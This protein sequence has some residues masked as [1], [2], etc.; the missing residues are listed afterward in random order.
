MVCVLG[1]KF[2]QL[3][4]HRQCFKRISFVLPCH[5]LSDWEP[6]QVFNTFIPVQHNLCILQNAALIRFT[7]SNTGVIGK[8]NKNFSQQMF[9]TNPGPM[10]YGEICYYYQHD[11][12]FPCTSRVVHRFLCIPLSCTVQLLWLALI[13]EK[14]VAVLWPWGKWIVSWPNNCKQQNFIL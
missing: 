3:C 9:T 10:S 5:R 8:M 2:W 6:L 1:I 4:Y 13:A 11:K 12:D 14:I 7:S